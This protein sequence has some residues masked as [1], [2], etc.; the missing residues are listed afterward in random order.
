MV[1]VTSCTGDAMRLEGAKAGRP[2]WL[3]SAAFRDDRFRG[4]NEYN[5]V[6][7]SM[8]WALYMFRELL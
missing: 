2:L 6:K 8:T 7:W 5:E 3:L 4:V 1:T